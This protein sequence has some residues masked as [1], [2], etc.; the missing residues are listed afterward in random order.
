MKN[1][2]TTSDKVLLCYYHLHNNMPLVDATSWQTVVT[3][4]YKMNR[5]RS[6]HYHCLPDLVQSTPQV[7]SLSYWRGSWHE[8][9]CHRHL[10]IRD[11]H[12]SWKAAANHALGLMSVPGQQSHKRPLSPG[13]TPQDA[14]SQVK[15]TKKPSG[16]Q[17]KHL[18]KPKEAP[19]NS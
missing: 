5:L 10:C 11:N 8:A 14:Q 3:C 13:G 17:W 15:C 18:R 12:T 1:M 19:Y 4:E 9:R 7:P 16:A 2:T 6:S